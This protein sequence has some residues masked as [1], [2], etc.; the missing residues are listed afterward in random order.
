MKIKDLK[1][2]EVL[3][4]RG[5]PTVKTYVILENG[6]KASAI[7][8]SGASTGKYEAYELRDNSERYHGKGVKKAIK[9]VYKI[10]EKI[11][12]MNVSEQEKIDKTIIELDGSENKSNL[13]ANAI[14]SV[15]MAISRAAALAKNKEL[16]EYIS[17][18]SSSKVSLPVP[19]SNILNGGKHAGNDLQIQ[20][21]MIS[22]LKFTKF[23]DAIRAISEIYHSLKNDLKNRYG[24][25]AINVGDEGGFAP[26]LKNPEDA[27]QL[28][29]KAIEENGYRDNVRIAMDA[30]ASEFY[31]DGKYEVIKGKLMEADELIDY[32]L[33]L[34]KDYKLVSL[35]DPFDEDDFKSFGKLKKKT[36]IQIVGDDLLVTNV[37]RI[38]KAIAENSVSAL[39]L[40]LNQIG[41]VTE[42]IQAAKLSYMHKLNVMVSHRSGETEDNYIADF[43][44][45]IGCNQIKSGAPARSERN[46]KYNRL[47]EIENF[48]NVP[49]GNLNLE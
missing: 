36:N 42:A 43:A 8:P 46:A 34:I 33:R 29:E 44:T 11:K 20:E 10:C 25:N 38:K 13:G 15:S 23:S 28:I 3:D 9:N 12:G 48:Y 30:A 2:F 24:L 14:L 31:K 4:S 40:K 6:L 7:V 17:E 18:L 32:Y 5:N 47:I 1:A 39:L 41:T 21:F 37:K 27:L 35:E 26:D 19:F 22:G 49:F 16:Y 45:G